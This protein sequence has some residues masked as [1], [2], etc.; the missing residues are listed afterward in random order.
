MSNNP[1]YTAIRN[2]SLISGVVN[3]A[4][5]II[6]ITVGIWGHS[7]VLMTDG[8]HSF[9]DTV[10]DSIVLLAA[11]MGAKKADQEHQ[12]GHH[13]IETLA[14]I[15]IAFSLLLIGASLVYLAVKSLLHHHRLEPINTLVILIAALS[16]FTN[17]G[18]YYYC[19]YKAKQVHSPLLESNALHNKSDALS[20]LMVIITATGALLGWRFLDPIGAILIA[21]LIVKS[22]FH[23]VKNSI[24]ELIDTAVDAPT[25]QKIAACIQQTEGVLA[26]HQVRTRLHSGQILV[27]CHILVDST[28]SVSEGHFIGDQVRATLFHSIPNITDV[29]VHIDPEDDHNETIAVSTRPTRHQIEKDIN[30]HIPKT[31]PPI[32]SDHIRLDYLNDAVAVCLTLPMNTLDQHA[33]KDLKEVLQE[34][35]KSL[36]YVSDVTIVLK[37]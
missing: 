18:L 4:L 17:Y 1:R 10:S 28:I 5:A 7:Q 37:P 33:L 36:H 35:I 11:K 3:S 34:K 20:S 15:I 24:N 29:T 31:L 30:Q 25:Y 9:S 27:D 19:A 6:K 32:V 2:T 12:Y 14:S 21:L 26:S 13:R 16:T 22:G 23:I 8:I